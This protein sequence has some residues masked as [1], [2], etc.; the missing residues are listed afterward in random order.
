MQSDGLQTETGFRDD[1][2]YNNAKVSDLIAP[3]GVEKS[4]RGFYHLIDDMAPRYNFVAGTDKLARVE[5]YTVSAG[6]ATPNAAYE[7]ATHE[8][9]F[10]L[11]PEVCEALIPNPMSGSNGLSFDPVNYRGKF[12]WKNIVSEITNPDGTIGFFRG[13]LASATKPIKTEFGFV[14]VYL[15]GAAAG[16]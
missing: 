12:D 8:A 6:V 7:T 15:R 13:V 9:A 5:P 10:V 16:A 2:R 1:I 4:F 14:I 11:H 3:L